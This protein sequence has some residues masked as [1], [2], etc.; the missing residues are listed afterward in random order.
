MFDGKTHNLTKKSRGLNKGTNNT[1]LFPWFKLTTLLRMSLLLW[2]L[3]LCVVA[4]SS[5]SSSDVVGTWTE[6]LLPAATTNGPKASSPLWED[7][8]TF[9]ADGTILTHAFNF[10]GTWKLS[11]ST[12]TVEVPNAGVSSFS[13]VGALNTT[14]TPFVISGNFTSYT[15]GQ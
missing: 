6:E 15:Q 4:V 9:N 7:S 1:L 10:K 5:Q 3:A 11:G 13:S 8:V 12:V 2:V 14:G